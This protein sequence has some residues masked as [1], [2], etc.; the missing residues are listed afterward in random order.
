VVRVDGVECVGIVGLGLIGGSVAKAYKRVAGIKVLGTDKDK[1]IVD[2]AQLA[3]AIDGELT[4]AD[5]K[6]CDV[7]LLAVFPQSVIEWVQSKAHLLGGTTVIDCA[8]TK[9]RICKT[10]FPIAKENNFLF[11]GGHPMAGLHRSGFKYSRED[12]FDG[13]PMVIVPPTHDDIRIF[14][15]IKTL[16]APVGFGRLSVTTADEHD[17]II[18]FASQMPHVISNAFVKSPTAPRHKGYSAGSYRDMSRVAQL[19]PNMWTELFLEN[20]EFLLQEFEHFLYAI[21]E[22]KKALIHDDGEKLRRLLA[23]GSNIKREVDGP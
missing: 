10:L 7:I 3:E 2:F 14:E 12:L 5:L 6:N 16:L 21:G 11:V 23:M 15:D 17:K 18:A 22:Y 4:D 19:D 8:G 9:G 20:K 1:S 13:E